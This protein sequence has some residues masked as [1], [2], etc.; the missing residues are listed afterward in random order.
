MPLFTPIDP[1]RL[2]FVVGGA[3]SNF[4]RCGPGGNWEFLG[5]VRTA[6]CARHDGLVDQYRAEGSSAAMAHLK[7]APALPA[8]VGSYVGARYHQLADQLTGRTK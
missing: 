2:E 8:A 3:D 1:P 7:A 6:A 4:G 5:D